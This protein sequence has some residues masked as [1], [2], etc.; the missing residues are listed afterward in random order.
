M[1]PLGGL[2]AKLVLTLT[3]TERALAWTL[4]AES[5]TDLNDEDCENNF[6]G[7]GLWPPSDY[8]SA[9]STAGGL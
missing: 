7:S 5:W 9:R 3:K 6:E 4:M 1:S 8:R 2:K